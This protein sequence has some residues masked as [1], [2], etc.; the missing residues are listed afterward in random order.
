MRCYF[1]VEGNSAWSDSSNR[2]VLRPG[3]ENA[4]P[5]PH[6]SKEWSEVPSI[7]HSQGSYSLASGG[8][9]IQQATRLVGFFAKCGRWEG[10]RIRPEMSTP[11][12]AFVLPGMRASGPHRR[13]ARR[14]RSQGSS[15]HTTRP[16]RGYPSGSC[17]SPTAV[18]AG[19]VNSGSSGWTRT[20]NPS[21]N[22]RLLCR[23]SYR[24][25]SGA[26]EMGRSTGETCTKCPYG[27]K[28]TARPA[29]AVGLPGFPLPR[30][31]PGASSN[32]P[33]DP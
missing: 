16:R 31:T 29:V 5:C 26:D 10:W 33:P 25:S 7:H 2:A 13:R 9:C 1:R 8:S 4:G 14:P 27:C 20:N 22:S 24:G 21:V 6:H 12:P 15:L 19:G 3:H 28:A 18:R 17:V 30:V 32:P 11:M 23:L